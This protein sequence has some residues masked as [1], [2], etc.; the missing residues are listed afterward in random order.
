[1]QYALR[2][3]WGRTSTVVCDR[4]KPRFT[5]VGG[6]IP[7]L[8]TLKF[9]PSTAALLPPTAAV[10]A[11]PLL[12]QGSHIRTAS[13]IPPDKL[14][15]LGECSAGSAATAPLSICRRGARERTHG[16]VR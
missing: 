10:G 12:K 5:S 13:L 6:S 9:T 1:M 15:T 7:Q 14:P 8:P 16:S 4:G 2:R 3:V 11:V